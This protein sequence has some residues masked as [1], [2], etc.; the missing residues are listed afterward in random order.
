MK[1]QINSGEIMSLVDL[2]GST[3]VIAESNQLLNDLSPSWLHLQ[4]PRGQEIT[5]S[6]FAERMI[7]RQRVFFYRFPEKLRRSQQ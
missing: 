1:P 6:S 3:L 2:P 4:T 7:G 5:V